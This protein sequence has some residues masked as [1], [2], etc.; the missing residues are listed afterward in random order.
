VT[1]K[2]DV[3]AG[4]DLA[5][6]EAARQHDGLFRPARMAPHHAARIAHEP[7]Q[8][9]NRSGV[10]DVEIAP[11]VAPFCQGAMV[12]RMAVSLSLVDRRSS[13]G[14]AGVLTARANIMGS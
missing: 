2:H 8:L 3:R 1:V 12:L 10:G 13:S 11:D 5:V 4:F 9:G 7:A 6:F 14:S